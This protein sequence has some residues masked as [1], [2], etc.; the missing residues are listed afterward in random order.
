MSK[1]LK[2]VLEKVSENN[3]EYRSDLRTLNSVVD[4]RTTNLVGQLVTSSGYTLDFS[5]TLSDAKEK[6]NNNNDEKIPFRFKEVTDSSHTLCKERH[7]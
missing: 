1:L 2:S 5:K 6:S 4:E 3:N 7:R